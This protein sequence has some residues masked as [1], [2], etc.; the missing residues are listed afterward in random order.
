MTATYEKIATTTVGSTVTEITFSSI[1]ASYTDLVLICNIKPSNT[2]WPSL[3]C[4]VNSDTASNYSG[5]FLYGD[6]SAAGSNRQT[7]QSRFTLSRQYGIGDS[8]SNPTTFISNFQNYS[9]TTTFKTVISRAN[10]I[11]S[12]I[13]GV[14]ANVG[15]WR[16]TS[17]IST[18]RV[19]VTAGGFASS[20]TFTL[21][22]IKSE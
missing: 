5:T 11:G 2:D 21:Y 15:L 7:S 18:I 1:T 19:F 13:N 6:G 8:T 4:Q 17:A 22:G 14:E 12:S 10:V 16:N 20:S 9:N 3:V